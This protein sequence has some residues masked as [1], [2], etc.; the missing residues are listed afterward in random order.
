MLRLSVSELRPKGRRSPVLQS[1]GVRI[2]TLS[3]LRRFGQGTSFSPNRLVSQSA[4]LQEK[5]EQDCKRAKHN[6]YR[7]LDDHWIIL[8]TSKAVHYFRA[9]RDEIRSAFDPP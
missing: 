3:S 4:M 9:R 7:P 5:I 1:E 2:R 8:T 6:N